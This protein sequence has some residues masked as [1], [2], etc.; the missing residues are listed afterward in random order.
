ML[1]L[2]KVTNRKG[3]LSSPIASGFFDSWPTVCKIVTFLEEERNKECDVVIFVEGWVN[4][5]Y[6]I[7][8]KEIKAAIFAEGK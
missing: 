4:K 1:P 5:D 2:K 7:V 8:N 6:A 3:Y